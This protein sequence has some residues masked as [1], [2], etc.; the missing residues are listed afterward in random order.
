MPH[1]ATLSAEMRQC[2]EECLRC[3]ALCLETAQHCLSMGGKHAEP[4]HIALMLTCASICE[5]SARAMLL[6]SQQHTETCRSCAVICRACAEDC[7]SMADGDETMVRCAEACDRC[8]QSCE[9]MA[10]A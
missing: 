1:A 2:V 10:G 7:R 9:Q 6:G 8:A 3:Y 4:Q 5:T